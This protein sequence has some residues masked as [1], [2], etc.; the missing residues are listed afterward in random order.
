MHLPE[1]TYMNYPT[2]SQTNAS[3]TTS[4]HAL[5]ARHTA[6]RQCPKTR[7][8]KW[9]SLQR[10][11]K[12]DSERKTPNVHLLFTARQY[13]CH[14]QPPLTTSAAERLAIESCNKLMPPGKDLEGN[15]SIASDNPN[16]WTRFSY[17]NLNWTSYNNTISAIFK[18][19]TRVQA[20]QTS[21]QT[22][23]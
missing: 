11:Y 4:S 15:R 10:R 2:A 7:R 20:K 1:S 18:M 3:A 16:W 9:H 23:W 5:V 6:A 8:S 13:I 22:R 19:T 12:D 14:D 21:L 17:C